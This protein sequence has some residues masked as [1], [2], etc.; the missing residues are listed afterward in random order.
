M[1]EA[2]LHG[3]F[4]EVNEVENNERDSTHAY[5]NKCI[6]FFRNGRC[7]TWCSWNRVD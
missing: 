6:D 4:E 5:E 3:V 2:G 1:V 7:I